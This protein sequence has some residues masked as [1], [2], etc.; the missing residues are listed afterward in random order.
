MR[1]PERSF[2]PDDRFWSQPAERAEIEGTILRHGSISCDVF[3][4]ARVVQTL[5]D[6]FDRR[7]CPVQVIGALYVFERYHQ[8]LGASLA[9]ARRT[10]TEYLSAGTDRE[11]VRLASTGSSG[12]DATRPAKADAC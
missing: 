7:A 1:V 11:A 8:S 2:H 3:G 6:F 9:A 12:R 5:R 4:R 10:N